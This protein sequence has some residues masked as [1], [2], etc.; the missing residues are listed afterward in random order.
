MPRKAFTLIPLLLLAACGPQADTAAPLPQ[1]A[2][3]RS[4]P[5]A[6]APSPQPA[7]ANLVGGGGG[8]TEPSRCLSDA[9]I[10]VAANPTNIQFGQS[11]RLSWS[12]RLPD[13]CGAV[14]VR[15]N[16]ATATTSES[17]TVTPPRST[18]FTVLITETRLGRVAQRSAS[19]QV[20]VGYP[21]RIII[22]GN[23]P[24]PVGVLISA[25]G[26]ANPAQ[27]VELCNIDLDFT[28]HSGIEIGA[29]RSVIASSACARG[30]RSSGPRI[31]VTDKR[32]G[33]SFLFVIRESN[34]H[35]SG[36]RLEGPSSEIGSA[37]DNLESG[38]NIFPFA[39][40]TPACD[41]PGL[42]HDIEI[43]N[44]EIFHWSGAGVSVGDN[45][46]TKE[47]GRLINE[48]VD[49]VRIKNNFFH[50]NRHFDGNG[51]GV[52]VAGGGYALI[53]QNVFDE[54]RHAIAGG[55]SDRKRDYSG[56]TVRDNLIFPGGGRHC[57]RWGIC[58]QTHQIDMH[59]DASTTFGGDWCC[60]TAGETMIIERN[61]ILYT[62]GLAIKIRGN[63]ADKA[64]VDGN[65]FRHQSRGD[66]I[67]QNGNPGFL[68]NSDDITRPIDV[69]PNN[70]FG[71]DDPMAQLGSCD[72]AGDGQ[73]DQFMATGVTWWAL[74]PTTHQWRYLN[75]MRERL[76]DV[77]LG[78]FDG[79]AVCDVA[80][81]RGNPRL[82]VL[83]RTYSKSGTGPWEDFIG[84][85][86]K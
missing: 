2:T 12:V 80:L 47:R 34:V 44:M 54:N 15:L 23:T 16:G 30:P 48:K 81:G 74:S 61:T 21:A 8:D 18:T 42:I 71:A 78:K 52:V 62:A 67:S 65:V 85:T 66:A 45:T 49:A 58:W 11:S 69:R 79:D 51:Y 39:C 70:I 56:Y 41:T 76:P 1:T 83:P 72:F 43:S 29:N 73:E 86:H 19:A 28:G 77:R 10:L 7:A 14:Q 55:S 5:L 64:V 13:G 3:A 6:P 75:T 33:H 35:F 27:V 26:S 68:D 36:F 50:H 40:E 57:S 37:A 25:L 32:D 31:F 22:D 17:R 38:I 4:P 53:E 84:T 20:D 63:P 46:E 60:G 82:P 24:D 9:T 59:G